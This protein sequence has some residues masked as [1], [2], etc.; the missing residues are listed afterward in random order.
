[1]ERNCRFVPLSRQPLVLVLCQV[2][3]SS[4]RKISDYIPAIQEDF[5]R[6]GYPIDRFD[7]IQQV[8]IGPNGVQTTEQERWE[9]RNKAET[10]SIIVL[11]DSA[12]IQ[13]TS[14]ERFEN[15]A[16]DIRMAS[17]TILSRTEHDKFG[18]IQRV[19]LRYI[20]IVQPREG[21]D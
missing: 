7:K 6:Q 9:F 13:T 10:Q 19:G 18:V 20:D 11:Q 2:K 8:N 5:R 3:Y 15:F 4:I 17:S 12:V 1:M 16:K 14:Y 21:E